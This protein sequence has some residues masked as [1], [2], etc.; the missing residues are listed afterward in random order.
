MNCPQRGCGG[1][2]CLARVLSPISRVGRYVTHNHFNLAVLEVGF[3]PVSD[4]PNSRSGRDEILTA[5]SMTVNLN[6]CFDGGEFG[7]GVRF[8]NASVGGMAVKLDC[9]SNQPPA[10]SIRVPAV[11][12]RTNSP[13]HIVRAFSIKEIQVQ[14]DVVGTL[15]SIAIGSV[16]CPSRQFDSYQ[17]PGRGVLPGDPRHYCRP[18]YQRWSSCMAAVVAVRWELEFTIHFKLNNTIE[19]PLTL[20]PALLF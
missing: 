10:F 15:L 3:V 13:G 12:S 1:H 19:N 6:W 7:S 5:P 17:A 16:G 20:R 2:L 8:A 4:C 18:R 9:K 14:S 11:P